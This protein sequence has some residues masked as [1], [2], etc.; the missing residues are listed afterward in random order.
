MVSYIWHQKQ[1]TK[2]HIGNLDFTEIKIKQSKNKKLNIKVH[3]Q[4]VKLHLTDGKE[5]F[6]MVNL[7]MKYS[8]LEDYI[9]NTYK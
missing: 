4:E 9:K 3:Y 5:I 1:E 8:L 7:V 2:A 6:P